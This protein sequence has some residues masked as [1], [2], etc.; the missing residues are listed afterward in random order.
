MEAKPRPTYPPGLKDRLQFGLARMLSSLP[1]PLQR[2]LTRDFGAPE[3]G[4]E[5]EPGMA[6][7]LK[8]ME[9]AGDG[10]VLSGPAS[11]DE[12]RANSR[13]NARAFARPRTA[14]ETVRALE[15]PGGS[16]PL[17]ARQ[18]R[19]PLS[20]GEAPPPLLVYAHGG[21]YIIGDLDTHD[22]ACR[23]LCRHAGVQVLS[24]DYRLAP[25]PRYPAAAD[26]LEAATGWALEAAEGLGADPS[27]VGVAGD[28]AGG[29]L[30]AVVCQRI[31]AGDG[32]QPALQLLIYPGT[33]F[34]GEYD[35]HDTFGEGLFLVSEDLDAAASH[36]LPDGIDR[37][38]P[39]VSPLRATDLSQLPTAVVATAAFDPI[40]DEGEAYAEALANAGVR[41]SHRRFP[42]LV[43]GFINMTNVNP[44]PRQ[45]TITIAG[46]LRSGFRLRATD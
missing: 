45:A 16:G 20:Y 31:A 37:S 17:S 38:D 22:E 5:L 1:R 9:L 36:Y 6:L 39:G 12:L 10:P 40:R 33:D 2:R 11:V 41:V 23:L 46:M 44:A 15:V 24:V 26:D 19:P 8:A 42:G 21:G 14:V 25:E 29:N 3:E 27:R 4:G 30:A 35:S 7:L 43:H 34:A 18:Y 28:S 13:R 32:P